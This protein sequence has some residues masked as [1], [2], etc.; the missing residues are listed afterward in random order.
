MPHKL[1][2]GQV[3]TIP[4]ENQAP[5]A[6]LSSARG[7]VKVREPAKPTWD[8]GQRGMNLFRA[9]RVNT[10]NQASAEITFRNNSQ[11]EMREDTVVIIYG[12]E[13]TKTR[14]DN[15]EVT[16]ESGALRQGTELHSPADM[17]ADI[18]VSHG[19]AVAA[20]IGIGLEMAFQRGQG[21]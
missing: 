4:D 20:D 1:K 9:W 6:K 12:A 5:D 17:A 15:A 21:Q 11:I 19:E 13:A 10:Q 3:L 7:A 8:N 18:D 16:L 2:A 14:I